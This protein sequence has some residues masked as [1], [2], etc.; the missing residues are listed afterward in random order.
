MHKIDKMHKMHKNAYCRI[1]SFRVLRQSFCG[2]LKL[3]AESGHLYLGSV[4]HQDEGGIGKSIP[5]AQEISWDPRD[6]LRVPNAL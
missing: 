2:K 5:D 1:D 4:I 3:S 6:L